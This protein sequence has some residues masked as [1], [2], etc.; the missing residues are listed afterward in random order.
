[1]D[2]LKFWFFLVSSW[3]CRFWRIQGIIPK[4]RSNIYLITI[5]FLCDSYSL[6]GKKFGWWNTAG[7]QGCHFSSVWA[8][9][10]MFI[11]LWDSRRDYAAEESHLNAQVLLC[12]LNRFVSTLQSTT[13]LVAK[14]TWH[15]QHLSEGL[16]S[17][18]LSLH[19]WVW[20]MESRGDWWLFWKSSWAV[21]L[22]KRTELSCQSVT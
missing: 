10:V 13:L 17:R 19:S 1:M 16:K 7:R 15:I 22:Q 9:G 5:P 14:R 2:I 6:H 20:I 11:L 8:Q 12:C 21:W 18:R 3:W 4:Q